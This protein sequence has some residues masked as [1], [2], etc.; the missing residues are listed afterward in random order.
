M[1][2]VIDTNVLVSGNLNAA[3]PPGRIIDMSLSRKIIL[4][5]D[6]R[7]ISE[8]EE[9]LRRSKFRFPASWVDSFLELIQVLGQH[10][11]APSLDV[12][13]TDQD[14]LV[15]LE[16]ATASDAACLITGN[17]RHFEPVNGHH[18]VLIKSPRDFLDH[19]VPS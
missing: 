13:L 9:V 17:M 14:D 1:L 16:V 19:W 3:G 15:F 18:K 4:A 12:T 10:T 5:Y 6:D 11:V 7:I 2:V 8:Y